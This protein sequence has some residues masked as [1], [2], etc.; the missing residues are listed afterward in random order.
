MFID[1][2]LQGVNVLVSPYD[3][4]KDGKSE[5]ENGVQA[6]EKLNLICFT[7]IFGKRPQLLP[8]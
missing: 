3:A 2:N 7:S 5:K 4:E 6:W 1:R 8:S